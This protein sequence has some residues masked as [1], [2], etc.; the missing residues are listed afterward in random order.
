MEPGTD[1]LMIQAPTWEIHQTLSS[2]FLRARFAENPVAYVC[3]YGA[4]FSDRVSAWIENEQDLRLNVIPGLTEKKMSYERL[5]HFMGIDIGMKNDG[6]AIAICHIVK[7]EVGGVM[8]DLIE[9]DMCDV[10][11]AKDE[12]KEHFRIEELADW[13]ASYRDKFFIVKGIT[14][15]E[16]GM[17]LVPLL[18]D[19]GMKQVQTIS[20]TRDL[21]SKVYSNLMTRMLDGGLRI[22]E[23][24]SRL[25]DGKKTKDLPLVTELLRLQCTH[26]SKYIITVEAPEVKGVHDDL[27]DAFARAVYLASEYMSNA[28]GIAMNNSMTTTSGSGEMSYKKYASKQKRGLIYTNRPSVG[29]QMELSRRQNI[30]S[31]NSLGSRGRWR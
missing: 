24:E 19:K 18:H 25:V 31:L 1:F 17:A 4:Q 29:L 23:G 3:E 6:T 5:P 10:R 30:S 20:F 28:G 9:L 12:D 27:C 14:D 8:R 13:I 26:H 15:Q 7:K 21:G 2:Q 16:Y 22:P 11:Y